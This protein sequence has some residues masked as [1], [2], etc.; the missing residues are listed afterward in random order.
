VSASGWAPPRVEARVRAADRASV[1]LLEAF[2]FVR[3]GTL[4]QS[5]PGGD[6]CLLFGLLRTERTVAA[7]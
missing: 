4:R 6:D 3:E 1:R 5:A 7:S 2:G